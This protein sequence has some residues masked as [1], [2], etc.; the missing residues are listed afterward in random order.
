MLKQKLSLISRQF[1]SL[2]I[3]ILYIG[4]IIERRISVLANDLYKL[5]RTIIKNSGVITKT[6]KPNIPRYL[7]HVTSKQNYESMLRSGYIEARK[8]CTEMK[9]V[10]MFDIINFLKRWVNTCTNKLNLG[11]CLILKPAADNGN[12]VDTVLL[13]ISTKNMDINKL[14]IRPQDI[15]RPSSDSAVYQSVYTRR[16]IPIEY[17]YEN[18]INISDIAKIGETHTKIV[19]F[20]IS[21]LKEI[22]TEKPF[23]ILVKLVKGQP[24]EKAVRLYWIPSYER[25]KLKILPRHKVSENNQTIWNK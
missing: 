12:E 17:I 11:T 13:R 18:D 15:A 21:D 23:N 8:D 16:K 4:Q 20:S 9:G 7:Y 22:F 1:F 5:G 19:A 25:K 6:G 14:K 10:F 24:E 2:N 3:F